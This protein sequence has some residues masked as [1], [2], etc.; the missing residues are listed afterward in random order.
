MSWGNTPPRGQQ[1]GFHHTKLLP[2]FIVAFFRFAV[3]ALLRLILNC[4]LAEGNLYLGSLDVDVRRVPT[5]FRVER[6]EVWD[7]L[8]RWVPPLPP[9]QWRRAGRLTAPLRSV[10]HLVHPFIAETAVRV[11][12]L[13]CRHR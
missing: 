2:P 5:I 11:R 3:R 6:L 7:L 8:P 1:K 10:A 13:C 12:C 4:A 9:H